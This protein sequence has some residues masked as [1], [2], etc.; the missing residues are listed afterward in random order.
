MRRYVAK[1]ISLTIHAIMATIALLIVGRPTLLNVVTASK[2]MK[3]MRR[4]R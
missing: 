2:A 1:G 3:A 4:R